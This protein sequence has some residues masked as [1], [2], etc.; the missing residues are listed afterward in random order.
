[1]IAIQSIGTTNGTAMIA[2]VQS[3]GTTNG[4]AMIAAV[5]SIG[6]MNGAGD[7]LG[8]ATHVSTRPRGPR[9]Q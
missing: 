1:M 8:Q 9:Y 6:T 5:Q 2:A 3:I 7:L 4:T